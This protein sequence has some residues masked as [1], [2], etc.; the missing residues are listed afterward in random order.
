MGVE[1]EVVTAKMSIH[2]TLGLD[3]WLA[4]P[5][6]WWYR[7][8]LGA[9][10]DVKPAWINHDRRAHRP[11][12]DVQHDLDVLPWPWPDNTFHRVY[13]WAVLE[14]LHLTLME[15]LDEIWRVLQPGGVVHVKVP[16]AGYYKAYRDPTH[17][18]RGWDPGVWTFFDPHMSNGKEHLY[19]TERKWKLLESGYTD[20]A[21]VALWA[22]LQKRVSKEQMEAMV[23]GLDVVAEPKRVIWVNGRAGA[24]KS[25]LCRYLQAYCPSL[26]FID[27][28]TLWHDVF[29][30]VYHQASGKK[31]AEPGVN[32]FADEQPGSMHR[33]FAIECAM[34]AKAFAGQGH[35]VVVDMIAS[36]AERRAHIEQIIKPYWVYVQRDKGEVRTPVFD[37]MKAA[38]L[39][40]DADKL[41]KRQAA[42]FA[43][44]TLWGEGMLP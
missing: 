21:K 3:P 44:M 31:T 2:E 25:T 20:K 18:W 30:Y 36:P 8:N 7:L 40:I 43:I 15:S 24:G 9:G 37:R 4:R 28:H 34:L 41:D 6:G 35:R 11:E 14:H 39:V 42:A 32:L 16:R 29:R 27:D 38:D 17:I 33:D 5:Y 12:I 22:R 10:N 26:V 13:A 23:N 19:Y 1:Q